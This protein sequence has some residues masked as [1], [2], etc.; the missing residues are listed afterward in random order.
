MKPL[1]FLFYLFL[2]KKA[3]RNGLDKRAPEK[4]KEGYFTLFFDTQYSLFYILSSTPYGA[5]SFQL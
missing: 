5:T 4:E 1:L 3:T 2:H